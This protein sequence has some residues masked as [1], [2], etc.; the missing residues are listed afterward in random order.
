MLI[1]RRVKK[2]RKEKVLMT[3]N[4]LNHF[5]NYRVFKLLSIISII[6]AFSLLMLIGCTTI[7]NI[8]NFLLVT[9]S[10]ALSVRAYWCIFEAILVS[11]WKQKPQEPIF[12]KRFEGRRGKEEQKLFWIPDSEPSFQVH[13]LRLL[14]GLDDFQRSDVHS[15]RNS[16]VLPLFDRRKVK[17]IFLSQDSR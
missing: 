12:D 5:L 7:L 4:N 14:A 8:E 3:N 11:Q 6:H 10:F 1:N 15:K 9:A 13:I 2:K 16:I 17:K